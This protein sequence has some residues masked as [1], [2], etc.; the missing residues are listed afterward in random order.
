MRMVLHPSS[1]PVRTQEFPG[2]QDAEAN[3][4]QAKTLSSG[5]PPLTKSPDASDRL[6]SQIARSVW[7]LEHR[8]PP[9]RRRRRRVA[10]GPD[11]GLLG[12]VVVVIGVGEVQ[13]EGGVPAGVLLPAPA[14]AT[15]GGVVP[16]GVLLLL[17]LLLMLYLLKHSASCWRW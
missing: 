8:G 3:S 11:E 13:E 14:A 17:L 10:K 15:A 2:L 5:S 12:A 1:P 7:T 4:F 6:N 9:G 16:A